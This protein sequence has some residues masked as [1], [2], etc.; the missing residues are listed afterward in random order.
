LLL[1]TSHSLAGLVA[2]HAKLSVWVDSELFM[3]NRPDRLG[4]V[5]VF[6]FSTDNPQRD[7]MHVPG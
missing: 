7:I 5:G 6:L 3:S 1:E 4:S 2:M